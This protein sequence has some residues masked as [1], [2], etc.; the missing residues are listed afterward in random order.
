MPR[1]ATCI[2]FS[3]GLANSEVLGVEGCVTEISPSCKKKKL[4]LGFISYI[5]GIL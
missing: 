2:C 1:S 3:V 4:S 5:L